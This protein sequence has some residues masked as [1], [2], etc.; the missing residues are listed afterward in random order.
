[1][2]KTLEKQIRPEHLRQTDFVREKLAELVER[3]LPTSGPLVRTKTVGP[4]VVAL[5]GPTGV[6]KTTTVAKLAANL[7]LREKKRVGLITIDTY[8]IAAADQIKMYAK[9]LGAPLKVVA[10]ANDLREAIESMNECDFVL[11]DT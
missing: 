9:I 3:L 1:I 6:G 2:I 5:I 4:H 7:H 8:R 11:I 10:S